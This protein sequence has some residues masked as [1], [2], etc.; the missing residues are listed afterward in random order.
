M[1]MATVMWT[2]GIL[3]PVNIGRG[4][5]FRHTSLRQFATS[6]RNLSHKLTPRFIAVNLQS[7]SP[8]PLNMHNLL[9]LAFV[10]IVTDMAMT[11]AESGSGTD[12]SS[13][14]QPKQKT[15]TNSDGKI[16]Q[17]TGGPYNTQSTIEYVAVMSG[18]Y[19]WRAAENADERAFVQAQQKEDLSFIDDD[20]VLALMKNFEFQHDD[21]GDDMSYID[22]DDLYSNGEAVSGSGESLRTRE[23]K[24][25]KHIAS[26]I[27]GQSLIELLDCGVGGEAF[28]KC[29]RSV[30]TSLMSA[31]CKTSTSANMIN[32]CGCYKLVPEK[33]TTTTT[34][35]STLTGNKASA[36]TG[37]VGAASFIAVGFLY[38]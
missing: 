4:G 35:D 16:A 19:E 10:V 25:N 13:G 30:V 6:R 23:R 2:S 20:E 15:N 33:V 38:L 29:E 28:G 9:T 14:A 12:A 5:S 26:W 8:T 3:H 31:Y 32:A 37:G 34:K 24:N 21:D 11:H 27:D 36:A 17:C 18:F 7:I 22:A 1:Q